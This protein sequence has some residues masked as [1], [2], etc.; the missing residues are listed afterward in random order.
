MRTPF[1]PP[2]PLSVPAEGFC[3]VP[4][5]QRSVPVSCADGGR[6]SCDGD[7]RN[8]CRRRLTLPNVQICTDLH[9]GIFVFGLFFCLFLYLLKE[10]K[11]FCLLLCLITSAVCNGSV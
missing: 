8:S 1:L 4:S 6:S 9:R 10:R 7:K 3:P 5:S 11:S 2:S